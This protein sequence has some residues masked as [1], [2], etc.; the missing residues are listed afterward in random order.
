M[1]CVSSSARAVTGTTQWLNS[2]S[3]DD[4]LSDLWTIYLML[5]E[6]GGKNAVVLMQWS[7]LASFLEMC[8]AVYFEPLVE[9]EGWPRENLEEVSLLVWI[10]SIVDPRESDVRDTE[11]FWATKAVLRAFTFGAFKV[12]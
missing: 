2:Y 11:L 1:V 6:N 5:M 10:F 4:L 3:A 8:C 9:R 12:T 7:H